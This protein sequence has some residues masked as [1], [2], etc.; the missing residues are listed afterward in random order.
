MLVVVEFFPT[1]S[2][3]GVKIA[4]LEATTI[5]ILGIIRE[6]AQWGQWTFRSMSLPWGAVSDGSRIV[7]WYPAVRPTPKWGGPVKEPR[8]RGN[9]EN[10]GCQV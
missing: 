4:V 2:V 8:T 6:A 10:G 7:T 3:S 5:T 9:N 1:K